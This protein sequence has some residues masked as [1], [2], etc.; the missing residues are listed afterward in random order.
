MLR[1]HPGRF[2]WVLALM[3]GMWMV[4]SQAQEY[5][6][7]YVSLSQAATD[8]G[9][10]GISPVK[11]TNN[12]RVYGTVYDQISCPHLFVYEN[13][14]LTILQVG[15]AYDANNSGTIGGSVPEF[16]D[17]LEC[18]VFYTAALVKGDNVE[19]LPL[20]GEY[21]SYVSRHTDSKISIIR[22]NFLGLP[23]QYSVLYP[24]G[25]RITVPPDLIGAFIRG[26]KINNQG[27]I[28]GTR[29]FMGPPRGD[30]AFVYDPQTGEQTLLEPLQNQL[31][32]GLDINNYGDVLG[33]SFTQF[34]QPALIG[35][36]K[37]GQFNTYFDESTVGF[38]SNA[39]SFNDN[40]VIAV[41]S[42]EPAYQINNGKAYLAPNPG[43]L[44]N[45]AD[46]VDDPKIQSFAAV[47]IRDI[48]N[49]GDMIGCG[50]NPI[51]GSANCRGGQ[52]F[53]LERVDF[54][55]K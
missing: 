4:G 29:V 45:L 31:S 21:T 55:S 20:P 6:Y 32:W 34:A 22:T 33:Y 9:A 38:V 24:N 37:N 42:I 16:S 53:L 7:H 5:R 14:S 36:W 13:G 41:S 30:R 48:N 10:I 15:T 1:F 44:L 17:P 49:H 51:Y 23:V 39:L 35:V 54:G 47:V 28:T 8:Q 12:G 11:I 25:E 2:I 40:N 46:I 18:R 43:E 52:V 19:L 50:Y 3:L 27:L 26:T